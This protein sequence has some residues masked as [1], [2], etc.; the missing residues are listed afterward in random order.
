MLFQHF[1]NEQIL[2]L[3]PSLLLLISSIIFNT[4]DKHKISL[5]LLLFASLGFAFFTAHLD[6]FL[7]LWDEQY[8]ALVAK[9]MA[10]N[11]FKPTLYANPVF[12]YD[13]TNW[14]GNHV[15]LHKQ[16]F[17]LWQMALSIKVFGTNELAVRIPSMLLHAFTTFLIYRIG[18]ISHSKAVAYY[19]ALFFSVAYY[20]LELVCG[21]YPTDHND[22]AFLFYVT[23]SIWAWLEYQHTQKKY[24]LILIGIFSGCAVLVKWLV[25]L[26]V[27]AIWLISVSATEKKKVCNTKVLIPFF[28]SLFITCIVFLPWQFFIF[29]QYPA[30]AKHEFD[31]NTQHFFTAVEGHAGNS[32][33]H[34]DALKKI[35]GSGDLVPLLLLA[36]VILYVKKASSTR[37]RIAI[38]SAITLVYVFYSLAATKMT[39]FC[40]IV[41]PFIF[42]GLGSLFLT[43]ISRL[44][45]IIAHIPLQK[46]VEMILLLFIC[47][48]LFDLNR[49]VNYHTHQKPHD[50]FG[51]EN[52]L[53]EMELI[54]KLPALLGHKKTV[55]FNVNTSVNGHIS[56]M[57]YTPY[58]AYSMVPNKEQIE[59]IKRQ[60]YH[61][62]IINMEQIPS[63]LLQD[64]EITKINP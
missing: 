29:T 4:T 63:F 61:I 50:N 48:F 44:K 53:K 6:P 5:I 42:L 30:E 59:K 33:F 24:W 32:W 46:T 40:L 36:G 56:V 39:A 25:G 10:Q 28:S 3:V 58:I 26:L 41:S 51:R 15:W 14:A 35:Y 60:N 22:T 19:G 34:F 2:P 47:Y 13:Y 21:K 49:M 31:L 7:N 23:A 18:N 8:H 37:Y 20:P 11:P 64:E 62:A 16:P 27:Y 57:F 38:V 54:H 52:D 17:F 1:T 55:L 43:F 12:E 9:N 45:K